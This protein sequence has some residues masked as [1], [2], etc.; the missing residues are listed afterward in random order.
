MWPVHCVHRVE[1]CSFFVL[2]FYT[3]LQIHWL[4]AP[5]PFSGI[6]SLSSPSSSSSGSKFVRSMKLL[7]LR[8]PDPWYPTMLLLPVCDALVLL[9]LNKINEKILVA[10]TEEVCID[11]KHKPVSSSASLPS[12]SLSSSSSMD[13]IYVF[14]F[15]LVFVSFQTTHREHDWEN[16][17]TTKKK[18]TR[19][20]SQT[21]KQNEWNRSFQDFSVPI[22]DCVVGCRG[23]Y[24]HNEYH[25]TQ[26]PNSR[27]TFI[28]PFVDSGQSKIHITPP[29]KRTKFDFALHVHRGYTTRYTLH[30]PITS[31]SMAAAVAM[32]TAAIAIC[33]DRWN[34]ET[35]EPEW[36]RER[37]N[38]ATNRKLQ[39]MFTIPQYSRVLLSRFYVYVHT[40]ALTC[41]DDAATC[42]VRTIR[43]G[44]NINLQLKLQST[45]RLLYLLIDAISVRVCELAHAHQSS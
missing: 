43:S 36:E 44:R 24:C 3:F 32:A 2:S 27:K 15:Y 23:H 16:D 13:S 19:I 26:Q 42:Y 20:I 22:C 28:L 14:F 4:L 9:A 1:W 35:N 10:F 41:L 18:K 31:S 40:L 39:I 38:T 37:Q 17:K 11:W 29:A 33:L 7:Y 5:G 25:T 30:Q 45:T 12:A 8:S 21:R 6:S 34:E